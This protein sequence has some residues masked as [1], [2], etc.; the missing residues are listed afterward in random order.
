MAT[1][2]A[3]AREGGEMAQRARSCG[4]MVS[5]SRSQR[6]APESR[7]RNEGLARAP[8]GAQAAQIAAP[9]CLLKKFMR[10]KST[11]PWGSG[12]IGGGGGHTYCGGG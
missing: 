6:V 2:F 10:E 11:P 5:M 3:L 4:A 1:F 8:E 12:F 9:S 7:G